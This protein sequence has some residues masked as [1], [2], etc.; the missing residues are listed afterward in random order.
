MV[1]GASLA[2][3]GVEAVIEGI[4]DFISGLADMTKAV[5][6]FGDEVGL[7]GRIFQTVTA[8]ISAFLGFV[9]DVAVVAGGVLM[10]D[11]IL[12][13]VNGLKAIA[14]ETIKSGIEF[15]KLKVRLDTLIARQLLLASTVVTT[16]AIIREA[17]LNELLAR[18]RLIEQI[19]KQEEAVRKLTAQQGA[20]ALVTRAAVQDLENMRNQLEAMGISADG[21]I[22]SFITSKETTLSFGD[23]LEQASKMASLLFVEITKLALTSLYFTPCM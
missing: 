11:A 6:G 9:R 21:M 16:T 23:A 7:L 10:R 15:Q 4:G 5:T 22:T 17:T 1:A 3:I 19:E 13:L 8:P 12:F 2:S 14:A 20:N 18:E